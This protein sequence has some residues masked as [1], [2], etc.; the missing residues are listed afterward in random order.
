MLCIFI[1]IT[2]L[3]GW[4]PVNLLRFSRIPFLKNTYGV[5][6]LDIYHITRN[7]FILSILPFQ[8]IN[9]KKYLWKQKSVFKL[10]S[11]IISHTK[12]SK[13]YFYKCEHFLLFL[14]LSTVI[15]RQ[16]HSYTKI[17]T[18]VLLIPTHSSL[19]FHPDSHH[20]HH[21]HPDSPHSHPD[22]PHSH[23]D[24]PH[25]H[26]FPHSAPQFP[27]SAFTD[28]LWCIMPEPQCVLKMFLKF[29]QI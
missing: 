24:S 23:P 16:F 6:L 12:V 7:T 10:V 3:H 15:I 22:S 1:E 17:L 5:L 20:S 11:L 28:S 8:F 27:I 21:S 18:R 26:H 2:L 4:S 13:L 14:A 9:I 25:S 19:H 29:W